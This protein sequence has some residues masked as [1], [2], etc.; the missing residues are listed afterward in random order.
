[1]AWP[2]PAPPEHRP[3]RVQPAHQRRGQGQRTRCPAEIAAG[4]PAAEAMRLL[5]DPSVEAADV[6]DRERTPQ[7]DRHQ[8]IP[9]LGPHPRQVDLAAGYAPCR[10]EEHTSELQSP[11]HL[12]CRLLL[13]KKKTK[14]TISNI[15][16][17]ITRRL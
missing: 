8:R 13:E 15:D 17:H 16:Q 4:D 10:S 6:G 12:V 5:G 7:R 3:S 9:W 14:E 1:P 2:G 11:D